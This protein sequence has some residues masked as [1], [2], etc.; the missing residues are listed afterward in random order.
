MF[1]KGEGREKLKLTG[2]ERYDVV[3]LDDS[4]R[5]AQELRVVATGEEGKVIEFGVICRIDTPV[6]I[7][8]YRHGGILHRVLRQM[9]KGNGR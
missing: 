9:L 5:P 2:R 8:Y 1:R 7:E 3:G 6:E 4:L